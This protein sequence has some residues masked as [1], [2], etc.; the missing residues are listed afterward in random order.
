MVYSYKDYYGYKGANFELLTYSLSE[1]VQQMK[2][3]YKIDILTHLN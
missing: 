1:L 3:I 2:A